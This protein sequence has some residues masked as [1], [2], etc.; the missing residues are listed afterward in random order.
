MN[1]NEILSNA[2]KTM[3]NEE[4]AKDLPTNNKKELCCERELD[5][6]KS[7]DHLHQQQESR[8]NLQS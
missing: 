7:S 8:S 6:Q 5:E 1:T 3:S 4:K 2:L